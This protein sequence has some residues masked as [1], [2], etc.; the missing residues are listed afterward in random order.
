QQK[1]ASVKRAIFVVS[2]LVLFLLV[3]LSFQWITQ[4]SEPRLLRMTAITSSGRAEPWG[5]IQVDGSRVYFLASRGNVW[6]LTQ[7]SV[8][9][10]ESTQVPAPFP[11][12]RIFGLS[13]D[14]STLLIGSFMDLAGNMPLWTMPAQGGPAHRVGDVA[15]DDAVWFPDGKRI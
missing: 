9:G 8:A 15:V 13:P 3:T 10:G 14:R 2:G 6:S 12:T 5:G 4:P 1:N 7:T 11:N